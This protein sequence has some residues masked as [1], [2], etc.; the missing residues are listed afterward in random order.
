MTAAYSFCLT[1]NLRASTATLLSWPRTEDFPRRSGGCAGRAAPPAS[2]AAVTRHDHTHGLG[3]WTASS[4][5][6][7][8][9]S[10][11]TRIPVRPR[12][13]APFPSRRRRPSDASLGPSVFSLRE[14]Q[15]IFHF[16]LLLDAVSLRFIRTARALMFNHF[17]PL[18]DF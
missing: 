5:R 8:S 18:H 1:H 16:L 17:C 10:C 9:L 6:P 4:L 13:P 11:S 7:V 12:P 3:A 2:S 15:P 14:G